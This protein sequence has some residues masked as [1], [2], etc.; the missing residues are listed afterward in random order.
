MKN[1]KFPEVKLKSISTDFNV[2]KDAKFVDTI[3]LDNVTSAE[4]AKTLKNRLEATLS[5]LTRKINFKKEISEFVEKVGAALFI[6]EVT[7][8]VVQKE[9]GFPQNDKLKP[10]LFL[11]TA[12]V[13]GYRDANLKKS[14]KL[15]KQLVRASGDILMKTKQNLD[16]PIKTN[17]DHNPHIISNNFTGEGITNGASSL[18]QQRAD[19]T[20]VQ[21]GPSMNR[22][23]NPQI[24]NFSQRISLLENQFSVRLS[25]SILQQAVNSQESFDLIL[26]PETFGRVRV[27]VSIDSSQ[28]DVKLIAEN[29]TTMA[30]LRSSESIL[31]NISEQ[32]GLKLAE[33][34]VEMNNNAHSNQGSGGQQGGQGVNKNM[35]ENVDDT[36]NIPGLI[37]HNEEDHSLNLIA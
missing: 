28:I 2:S 30:I 4:F 12:D 6:Q 35:N 10:T 22:L 13:I 1:N 14:D 33:Y 37:N 31:Q 24:Q 19:Q 17:A 36:E 20:N 23:D 32:N 18:V 21:I 5:S 34:N 16:I 7:R 29:S 27:N 26:E 8:K 3:S 9:I 11:S 25:N 15:E